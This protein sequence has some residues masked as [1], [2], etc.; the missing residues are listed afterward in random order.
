MGTPQADPNGPLLDVSI[1]SLRQQ[2]EDWSSALA[3]ERDE[4]AVLAGLLR[5][6]SSIATIDKVIDELIAMIAELQ[7]RQ[8]DVVHVRSLLDEALADGTMDDR[9]A[10]K[11]FH[12]TAG[13]VTSAMEHEAALKYRIMDLVRSERSGIGHVVLHAIQER[14]SVRSYRSDPVP[15]DLI[16][17]IIDAGRAAPSALDRQLWRFH[18]TDDRSL[19]RDMD[20]A[21]SEAMH[22]L[23]PLPHAM[24]RSGR[25]GT[26]FHGAPVVVFLSAPENDPW[27]DLDMGACAQNM[28]LAA[29]A[30]GLSTCPVGLGRFVAHT[31]F[32]SLLRSGPGEEVKLALV[33]G[34]GAEHPAMPARKRDN[35]FRIGA[36]AA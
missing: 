11:A 8:Q 24:E 2:C 27:A 6:K 15:M 1:T 29:H 10:R 33:I 36:P 20:K 28:M 22:A 21:I 9:P 17:R 26:I 18:V 4:L 13:P 32:R 23:R 14:R 34:I 19:I 35:L 30:L 3:F 31:R 16:E 5:N 25:T 7:A 12:R